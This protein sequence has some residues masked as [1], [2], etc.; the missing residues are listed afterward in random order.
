MFVVGLGLVTVA[1]IAVGTAQSEGWLMGARTVQGVGAAILAPSTL[2]LLQTS[3]TEGAERTLA[4]VYY[5]AIA[6][7]AAT[8]ASSWAA[9][10]PAGCLVGSVSSSTRRSGS[11]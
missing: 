3:F 5:A 11:L 7:V 6:S 4:V 1:S 10:S 2:A 9:S 8:S